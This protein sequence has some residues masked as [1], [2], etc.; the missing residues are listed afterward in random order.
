M[1]TET[2]TEKNV[3]NETD[4]SDL[5]LEERQNVFRQNSWNLKDCGSSPTD[6]K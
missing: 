1:R 4:K 2:Y 6:L 5:H 3:C